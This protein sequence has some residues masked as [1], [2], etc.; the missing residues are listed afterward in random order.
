M[1]AVYSTT[2]Q[3]ACG[4]GRQKSAHFHLYSPFVIVRSTTVVALFR[5]V[6]FI[7][8]RQTDAVEPVE[9]DRKRKCE[10]IL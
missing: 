2:G 1:F 7:R 3:A 8:S 9:L 10:K 4:P 6:D 5:H